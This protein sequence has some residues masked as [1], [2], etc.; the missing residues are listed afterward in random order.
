MNIRR[1]GDAEYKTLFNERCFNPPGERNDENEER[2]CEEFRQ[3]LDAVE[4]FCAA[5]FTVVPDGE[6][7]A[8][9]VWQYYNWSRVIEVEMM[10]ESF[11]RK[12]TITKLQTVLRSLPE[13]WTVILSLGDA[14]FVSPTEVMVH[15]SSVDIER[16]VD[17]GWILS[18]PEPITK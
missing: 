14:L 13:A 16:S 3:A 10:D 9:S 11:L 1:I 8:F 6:D 2:F 5:E 15:L 12:D 17:I 18:L 7:C 4:E